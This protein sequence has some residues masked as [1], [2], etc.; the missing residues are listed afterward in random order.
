MWSVQ[1][2]SFTGVCLWPCGCDCDVIMESAWSQVLLMQKQKPHLLLVSPDISTVYNQHCYPRGSF[3]DLAFSSFWLCCLLIIW[4][5][6][7]HGWRNCK[8][9]MK[10]L[11]LSSPWIFMHGAK[12]TSAAH[13]AMRIRGSLFLFSEASPWHY[14]FTGEARGI[15]ESEMQNS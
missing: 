13:T 2:A 5:G 15:L 6:M 10:L 8:W 11:S 7:I 9:M 14:R 1:R 12:E 4:H 3:Q